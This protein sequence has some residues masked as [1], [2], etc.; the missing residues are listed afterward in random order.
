MHEILFGLIIAVGGSLINFCSTK[1]YSWIT[2][3]EKNFIWQDQYPKLKSFSGPSDFNALKRKT[4]IVVIDDENSFPVSLFLSDGYAVDKWDKVIDYGK[5]EG[6]YYDIIVLDIKGVALH[7]SEDDGLGVLEGIKRK[8][9]AQIIIAYSQHSFDLSKAKFW[10]LADEKIAKPSDY[11]KMKSIIDNLINTQFKPVRYI[12]TLHQVL[13]KNN[14][15]DKQIRKLD[16]EL[17]KVIEGNKR[18]NWDSML[19]FINNRPEVKEQIEAIGNTI[20]KFF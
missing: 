18:P 2:G 14:F 12:E 5:L 15:D 8:N 7:I 1:V 19:E 9:P 20:I 4:K 13:K 11:L 10:E 3:N 6:G 17:V 16:S